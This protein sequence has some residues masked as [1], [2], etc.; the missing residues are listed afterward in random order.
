MAGY[1]EA[2]IQA[3]PPQTLRRRLV[4]GDRAVLP[5]SD[6]RGGG[7]YGGRPRPRAAPVRGRVSGLGGRHPPRR[8]GPR[9]RPL[10][11]AQP[12]LRRLAGPQPGA[13]LVGH[14]PFPDGR[15]RRPCAGSAV[16]LQRGEHPELSRMP[17]PQR[18]HLLPADPGGRGPGGQSL[19]GRCLELP[20][21]GIQPPLRYR[22]GGRPG[23]RTAESQLPPAPL[24]HGGPGGP[25]R[26]GDRRGFVRRSLGDQSRGDAAHPGIRRSPGPRHE[27]G[28]DDRARARDRVRQ[29]GPGSAVLSVWARGQPA[30]GSLRA[31]PRPRRGLP[32]ADLQAAAR[33]RPRARFHAR[34]GPGG[35]HSSG[36][37]IRCRGRPDLPGQWARLAL[38]AADRPGDGAGDRLA[39]AHGA[40]R[41]PAGPGFAGEPH[42][43]NYL[44]GIAD[45]SIHFVDAPLSD[46]D[47]EGGR[48]SPLPPGAGDAHPRG[49][50]PEG[51]P[52]PFVRGRRLQP[53][54]GLAGR[55]G[56]RQR[57]CS[58]HD[59]RRG[60][61]W[62]GQPPG[63]LPRRQR[64]RVLSLRR[65]QP[66]RRRR[67]ARQP[68]DGGRRQPSD[69]RIRP[70]VRERCRRRPG[71]G[72]GGIVHLPN[73]Q[74]RGVER[75]ACAFREPWPSTRRTISTSPTWRTH[76]VLLFEHPLA[77][78][79]ASKVF[80][81]E[82]FTQGDCNQ[83]HAFQPGAATLCLGEWSRA[84]PIPISSARRA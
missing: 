9:D 22:P 47:A 21:A 2:H 39:R 79:A 30:G 65:R 50:R 58:R 66:R 13:R 63:P 19:R 72:A 4:R 48:Q 41:R 35:I 82:G 53:G 27:A 15:P 64:D 7:G 20:G 76:R 10:G 68:L 74:P 71:A 70:P 77:D 84:S 17:G 45:S 54:A 57:L 80:G 44:G 55:R 12:G 62:L 8:R 73:L 26:P 43:A 32:G 1:E 49:D 60:E 40:L 37:G 75:A 61:P 81:Q 83:G 56:A 38:P 6:P 5:P 28:P 29:R 59:L 36:R 33:D 25:G 23:V 18:H 46:G 16:G 24:R 51:V 14:R 78:D 3:A 11:R 42:A 34:A 69:A 31:G 67:L 52:Q